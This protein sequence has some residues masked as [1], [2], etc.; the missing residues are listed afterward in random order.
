MSSLKYQVISGATWMI[1]M[2]FALNLTGILSTLI[3]VR[4]LTPDDFGVVALAGSA[5]AFLALLGQLG[6]D[7]ALIHKRDVTADHYNSAWTANILIGLTISLGTFAVAKPAALFFDDPRI[8]YVVYAFSLLSLAK[9][10]ENIGVVNFRKNLQFR[11]DFFYFVIPKLAGVSVGVATAV[12]LKSYWALVAGMIASQTATLLYSHFSQPFRPRF[13]TSRIRELFG[14]S[15]WILTTNGLGYL[16]GNGVEIVLGKLRGTDAVGI[17]GIAQQI[18]SLPSNELLAPINRA[19]FPGFATVSDDPARLSRILSRV[20]A[21]TALISIPAASGIVVLSQLLADVVLGGDRWGE[22]GPLLG[23]L[24]LTGLVEAMGSALNPV[25]LA[26]G[27]PKVLTTAKV[28]Q[29]VV[30]LP[31]VFVLVPLLGVTG[32]GY[33]SLCGSL[34]TL[35]VLLEFVRRDIGFGWQALMVSVWRPLLASIVMAIGVTGCEQLLVQA[36][37]ETVWVLAAL[38]G[39]GIVLFV[40]SVWALWALAGFAEGPEREALEG[41]RRLISTFR[42]GGPR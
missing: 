24:G 37:G 5:Y 20:I 22:V 14:Y 7:A 15:R 11:G 34:V 4:F 38:I 35:P 2:R 32:V 40:L 10:F 17:Y 30:V 41:L 29:L 25:L 42:G 21:I 1:G 3:L 27:Q 28:L 36:L 19:L 6:F 18:A 26:R 33:A 13:S 39:I 12:I 23:V 8:E 16:S 31:A 9:G